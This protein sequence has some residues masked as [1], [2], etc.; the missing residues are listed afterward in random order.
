LEINKALKVKIS[1]IDGCFGLNRNGPMRGD[2]VELNWLMVANNILAA[3]IVCS[4]LMGIDPDGI[5]YLNYYKGNGT[6]VD[7]NKIDFNQ[8]YKQF[9]GPKFYLK[10]EILDYPGYFA[11]QSELLAYLAYHSPLAGLLHKIL[12]LFREKFYEHD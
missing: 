1:V 9:I 11:F 10:R 12:Y 6:H 3:D 8:N 2:P 7:I 5:D 4:T